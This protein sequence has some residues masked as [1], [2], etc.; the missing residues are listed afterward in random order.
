MM[1]AKGPSAALKSAV[2]WSA[3]RLISLG[4]NGGFASKHLRNRT[5]KKV[6]REAQ[7]MGLQ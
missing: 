5:C 7:I 3:M 1:N 4:M 6:Q 2:M